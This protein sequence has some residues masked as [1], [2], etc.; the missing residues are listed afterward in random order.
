MFMQPTPEQ[1]EAW[2][3]YLKRSEIHPD[4]IEVEPYEPYE[5]PLKPLDPAF[6]ARIAEIKANMPPTQPQFPATGQA[7]EIVT[8]FSRDRESKAIFLVAGPGPEGDDVLVYLATNDLDMGT[9]FDLIIR[10]EDSSFGCDLLIQGEMYSYLD[11]SQL[12][13]CVGR[14]PVE[15]AD[16][17]RKALRSDG[18]SLKPWA[19]N[20][21]IQLSPDWRDPRRYYKNRELDRLRP[22]RRISRF[23]LAETEADGQS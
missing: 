5:G 16:G 10:S 4:D 6:A 21:P 2:N 23:E 18:E 22:F 3:A 11:P 12:D 9:D 13:M 14:A 15:M 1:R 8:A 20:V 17:M 7:G 19:E